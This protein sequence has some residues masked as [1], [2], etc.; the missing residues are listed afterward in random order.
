MCGASLFEQ[1]TVQVGLIAA[2]THRCVL[3]TLAG[4]HCVCV[5]VCLCAT[6]RDGV[7]VSMGLHTGSQHAGRPASDTHNSHSL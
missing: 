6:Q 1:F 7:V 4:A 3:P 5:C 2:E